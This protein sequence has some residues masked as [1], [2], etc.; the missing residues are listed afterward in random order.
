[1]N[2]AKRVL[3][4]RGRY[5]LKIYFLE[6]FSPGE[7]QGRKNIGAEARG[8][9]E[10]KLIDILRKP[11]REFEYSVAPVRYQPPEKNFPIE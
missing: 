6:P 2:N 5:S 11:L 7:I 1:M 3:S 10:T 4:H 9:I 8:R